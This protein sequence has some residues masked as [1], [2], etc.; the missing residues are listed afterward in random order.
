MEKKERVKDF[1]QR[2]QNVLI[3]F[4]HEVSP[5]QYLAIEYYT[6][7]IEYYTLFQKKEFQWTRREP[8][9]FYKLLHRTT[10]GLC[11]LFLVKSISSKYSFQTLLRL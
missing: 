6:V 3:K 5:A 1:N 2:F 7:S 8:K 4:P 11:D 10:R 9:R